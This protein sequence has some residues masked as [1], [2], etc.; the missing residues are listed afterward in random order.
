M[1]LQASETYI[2]SR[3]R[4]A[5]ALGTQNQLIIDTFDA[6]LVV[7]RSHVKHVKLVVAELKWLKFRRLKRTGRWRVLGFSTTS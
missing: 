5:V 6:L 3:H 1:A 4:P 7:A 2:Y